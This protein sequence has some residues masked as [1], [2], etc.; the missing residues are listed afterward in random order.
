MD[1]PMGPAATRSFGGN[2]SNPMIGSGMQQA[3]E[4]SV[5]LNGDGKS[6]EKPGDWWRK[7]AGPCETVRSEREMSGSSS[8]KRWQHRG[9]ADTGDEVDGGDRA[10]RPTNPRGGGGKPPTGADGWGRQR[11]RPD[12]ERSE[13]HE[14]RAPSRSRKAGRRR[15]I[16]GGKPRRS[17]RVTGK[18]ERGAGKAHD[19]LPHAILVH[20]DVRSGRRTPRTLQSPPTSS[21]PHRSR[22]AAHRLPNLRR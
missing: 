6:G 9:K 15:R 7:P 13:A 5:T 3:R 17:S 8:P 1:S 2:T 11:C 18:D 4:S 20:D 21:D 22:G 12:R 10:N 14:G 19:P 16:S